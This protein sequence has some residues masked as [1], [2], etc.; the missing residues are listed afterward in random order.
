MWLRR[1][2]LYN[3]G[4]TLFDIARMYL[5]F[6][7]DKSN[8]KAAQDKITGKKKIKKNSTIIKTFTQSN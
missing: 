8:S 6:Q 7:E 2:I 1:N 3:F 5:L 4:V